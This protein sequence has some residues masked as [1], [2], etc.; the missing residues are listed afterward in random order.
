MGINNTMQ[1]K[2][3]AGQRL[4]KY[5][6]SKVEDEYE[7]RRHGWGGLEAEGTPGSDLIVV[8]RALNQ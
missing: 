6:K 5:R 7:A 4:E 8:K 1:S 2:Y 3:L